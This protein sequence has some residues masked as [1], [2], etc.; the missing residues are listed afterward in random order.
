MIATMG[1]WRDDARPAYTITKTANGDGSYTIR[2]QAECDNFFGCVPSL[3]E[4][5]AN[6][7][8]LVMAETA[9]YSSAAPPVA[10]PQFD[11]VL[12]DFRRSDGSIPMTTGA[13]CPPAP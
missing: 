12:V 3:L 7:V 13:G 5:K 1:P 4:A 2:F 11:G 9:P 10:R 8:S 6:F